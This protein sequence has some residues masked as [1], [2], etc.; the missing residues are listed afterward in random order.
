[1]INID[2]VLFENALNAIYI[3]ALLYFY[4]NGICI[5]PRG[6]FAFPGKFTLFF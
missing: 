5:Y 1:L 2:I 3:S 6:E 4:I